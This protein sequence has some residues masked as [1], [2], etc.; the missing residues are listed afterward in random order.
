MNALV[1]QRRPEVKA[2]VRI[3]NTVWLGAADGLYRLVDRRL[4][5]AGRWAG[6]KIAALAQAGEGLILAAASRDGMA[7]HI[8]DASA[9]VLRTLPALPGDEPKSLSA[10]ASIFAGGKRGIYRLDAA[11]WV[12]VHGAGHTE[13]I[14]LEQ[15]G[16]SVRA[17]AKK[18]GPG[19][20][21][22][23]IVSDDDGASWSIRLE[24]AYHDGVLAERAGRYVTRWRGRWS[25]GQAVHYEKDAANV[26]V[27]EEDRLAW[28]A[29]NK[30]CLR[31]TGGARLDIKDARFAEA[32]QL[33]LLPGH[34]LVAGGNGAWLL[35]LFSAR[36]IDLFED[37]ETAPE[38]AK[39]KKLWLLEDG[40]LL[41]TASYGTFYSD[42][43]GQTWAACVSD[44]SVLDAEGLA[45][46]PDGAW[47]MAA[48]RGLFMSWDNGRS[49]KQVKLATRPHFAEF[50]AIAFAGDRLLLGGKAGLFVSEPGLPK[51]L[52]HV[53]ELRSRTVAGLLVEP[54]GSVLVGTVDGSLERLDPDTLR[55]EVLALFTGAC[56]PLALHGAAV[57]VLNAGALY[58]VVA[59]RVEAVVTPGNAR[60]M[61]AA[62]SPE[63][64]LL[65]WNRESG[66]R[67][68]PEA[69]DWTAVP[70]WLPHVKSV[71]FAGRT[72]VTDRSDVVA[73]G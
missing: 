57:H 6:Q 20:Q 55:L 7:I 35:D 22:A 49:W 41:A 24:T 19:A 14:A 15:V 26:A 12:K 59:G 67:L 33:Q 36:V 32:E 60:G 31:W 45:L 71:A 68:P 72:V 61:D 66:W 69:G 44:W 34:A 65:V 39:I 16:G 5:P 48:Q 18:Q 37:H 70:N 17:F 29:G 58:R 4:L 53:A 51:K 62:A 11:G 52:G 3:G 54:S 56:R 47:Y 40:R 8:T 42:D 64:A 28:I 25:A 73:V 21:P 10:G 50:T 2:S 1:T 13:I 30:L 27:F 63:G 38:A 46:S 9:E 43:E 23:L